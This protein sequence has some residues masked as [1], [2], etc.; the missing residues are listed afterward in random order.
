[1][2]RVSV[3]YFAGQDGPSL[4]G[5]RWRQWPLWNTGSHGLTTS[6]RPE[7]LVECNVLACRRYTAGLH[8]TAPLDYSQMDVSIAIQRLYTKH[9][10]STIIPIHSLSSIFRGGKS[11][12]SI[13]WINIGT[14]AFVSLAI[15]DISSNS[16]YPWIFSWYDFSTLYKYLFARPI[17]SAP[18]L[19]SYS[20]PFLAFC[21]SVWRVTF[22]SVRRQVRPIGGCISYGI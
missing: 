8:W 12:E 17:R 11:L 6:P 13:N 3:I 18:S 9:V 14:L 2:L 21:M 7:L 1:M 22:S 10:Y 15:G 16:S 4:G 19:S 20:L 5:H